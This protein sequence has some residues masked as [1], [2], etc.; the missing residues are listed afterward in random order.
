MVHPPDAGGIVVCIIWYGHCLRSLPGRDLSSLIRGEGDPRRAWEPLYFMTDDDVTRGL[1]QQ[2]FLGWPYNSVLQPNH[3]ET[4]IAALPGRGGRELW[5]YSR[6]FDSP[7][8]W[9]NPGQ[10]DDVL[11]E[12]GPHMP[13]RGN[14]SAPVCFTT[15]KNRPVPDEYEMYNLTTDPLEERNL[16]NPRYAN[17]YTREMQIRLAALLREQCRQKRLYPSGGAVPGAPSCR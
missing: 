8:F 5:K 14:I 17:A 7:Q 10:E 6:Y 4:V 12:F 11:R 16:A 13:A 9:T 15:Q 1:G 2:N 3:V